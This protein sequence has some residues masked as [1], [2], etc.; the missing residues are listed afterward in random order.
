MKEDKERIE[1]LRRSILNNSLTP[2]PRDLNE[3]QSD[4]KKGSFRNGVDT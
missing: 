1:G 2:E 3:I 4:W